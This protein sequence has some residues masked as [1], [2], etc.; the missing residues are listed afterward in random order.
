MSGLPGL[1]TEIID[2]ILLCL[3]VR[4]LYA[5]YRTCHKLRASTNNCLALKRNLFSAPSWQR[6]KCDMHR[7][8]RSI[9]LHRRRSGRENPG[10]EV[11]Q[12]NDLLFQQ[13]TVR[14]RYAPGRNAF[15]CLALKF[16]VRRLLA[17]AWDQDRQQDISLRNMFLTQPPIKRCALQLEGEVAVNRFPCIVEHEL[18]VTLHDVIQALRWIGL[19]TIALPRLILSMK[20]AVCL[21][22]RDYSTLC[23]HGWRSQ[24][25]RRWERRQITYARS[26]AV[27]INSVMASML[28][29][30]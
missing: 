26:R 22:G 16:S 24:N 10:Y 27:R 15:A 21:G 9:T 5:T 12:A 30:A 17:A 23:E 2:Q 29:A 8:K 14:G 1:P 13:R 3:S 4:D 18:G 25:D 28:P 20:G 11:Y 7:S 6:Q 19:P